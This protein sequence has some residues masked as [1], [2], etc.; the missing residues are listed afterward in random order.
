MN[1]SSSTTD[2]STTPYPTAGGPPRRRRLALLA[3]IGAVAVLTS[4]CGSGFDVNVSF[5]EE[6]SGTRFEEVVD[7]D[8]SGVDEVEVEG[9]WSVD[10]EVT[11]EDNAAVEI[12]LDDNF[13]EYLDI[14]VDGSVLRIAFERG[15]LDPTI[16]PV[17]SVRLPKVEK[18]DVQ[19]AASLAMRGDVTTLA[20]IKVEG[21][22]DV[23][24]SDLDVSTLKLSVKGASNASISG[25]ATKGTF[26]LEGASS[27]SLYALTLETA[28]VSVEGASDLQLTVTEQLT[29]KAEGASSVSVDGGAKIDASSSG[30]SSIES[31]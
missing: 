6:G 16:K 4:A 19:G 22:S 15:N 30:A 12:V 20:D 13:E 5:G 3:L 31:R 27:A 25:Q 7:L 17:A 18:V 23:S 28:N 24:I 9:I 29:G 2:P 14:R 21:A 11:D 8:L 26:D 10:L 1:I